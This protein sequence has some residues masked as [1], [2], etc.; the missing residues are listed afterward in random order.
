MKAAGTDALFYYKEMQ[1]AHTP[2]IC[3]D[4]SMFFN[5][6]NLHVNIYSVYIFYIYFLFILVF[7]KLYVCAELAYW[8]L[9]YLLSDIYHTDTLFFFLFSIAFLFL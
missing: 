5:A 8:R 4:A 6:G 1:F 7:H 3:A 2:F 9:S